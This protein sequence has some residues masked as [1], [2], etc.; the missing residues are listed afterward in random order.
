MS[1]DKIPASNKVLVCNIARV[2][3]PRPKADGPVPATFLEFVCTRLLGPPL[4][5]KGNGECEWNCPAC[6]APRKFHTRPHTPEFLDRFSCYK[7]DEFGHERDF[8]KLMGVR[9]EAERIKIVREWRREYHALQQH[10]QT[11]GVFGMSPRCETPTGCGNTVSV[12]AGLSFPGFRSG[13]TCGPRTSDTW[14]PI[15]RLLTKK[16]CAEVEETWSELNGRESVILAEAFRIMEKVNSVNKYVQVPFELLAFYSHDF[17]EWLRKSD[18]EYLRT[19]RKPDC[20]SL[21]CVFAREF[22]DLTAEE[23]A[24][25]YADRRRR[26]ALGFG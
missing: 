14:A 8:L 15:S 4:V 2:P 17:E 20:D 10:P 24:D 7:C 16:Q 22:P 5:N 25:L 6:L 19:C 18:A 3:E 21:I 26:E 12:G 13:P 11:A 9:H 23:V 1:I